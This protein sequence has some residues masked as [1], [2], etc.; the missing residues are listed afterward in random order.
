VSVPGTM[1]RVWPWSLTPLTARV[2]GAVFC[3]G[4]A[5]LVAFTDARWM[6]VRVLV[7]AET[8]M[9]AAMLVSLLRDRAALHPERPLTWLLLAGMVAALLG[10][11]SLLYSMSRPHVAA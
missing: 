7:E 2:I 3:L 9:V 11:A 6:R 10:S 1:S 4:C 5:G 8:V